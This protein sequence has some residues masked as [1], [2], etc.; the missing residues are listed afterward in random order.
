M[1]TR[2][3]L[4]LPIAVLHGLPM[5]AVW[6]VFQTMNLFNTPYHYMV[7][8]YLAS[9]GLL[10]TMCSFVW[11]LWNP[12]PTVRSFWQLNIGVW[13]F[14]LIMIFVGLYL[15]GKMVAYDLALLFASMLSG[16]WILVT[17]LLWFLPRERQ[18]DGAW[19]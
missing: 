7:L 5:A 12:K 19:A 17:Y 15:A 4:L 9:G 11:L 3:K 18:T 16:Y 10:T 1:T 14:C 13:L 2:V 8:S 6:I